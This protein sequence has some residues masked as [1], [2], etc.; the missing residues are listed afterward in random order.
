[1]EID[2]VK[3]NFKDMGQIAEKPRG[4]PEKVCPRK[5]LKPRDV[6][7]P[8]GSPKGE[9]F[10]RDSGAIQMILHVRRR[11]PLKLQLQLWQ[12]MCSL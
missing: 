6:P 2:G 1:M 8:S 9:L 11:P 7:R 4:H 3:Y 5:D 10:K 12:L